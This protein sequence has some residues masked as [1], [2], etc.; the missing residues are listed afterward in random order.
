MQSHRESNGA[1]YEFGPKSIRVMGNQGKN[2]LRLVSMSMVQGEIQA[3]LHMTDSMGP[4]KLVRHIHI[5][6][7]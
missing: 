6:H 1:V 5:I 4:G 7:T 3:N 2:T